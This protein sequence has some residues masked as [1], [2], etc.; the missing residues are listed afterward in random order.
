MEQK[1]IL[2]KSYDVQPFS[3]EDEY[4]DIEISSSA[5]EIRDNYLP[6]NF[7][8]NSQYDTERN[9]SRKFFVYGRLYGKQIDTNGLLMTL[10]TSDNDVL[11]VPNKKNNILQSGATS[12]S[13]ITKPLMKSSSLS[14]NIFDNVECSYYFQFEIDNPGLNSGNTKT[15]SIQVSGDSV[16]NQLNTP[17]V[18]Y[19]IDG[20]YVPYGT[21]DTVFD[22]NYNLI[23]INNNF[24]FLYDYHW[25]KQDFDV[26][27]FNNIYFPYKQYSDSNGNIMIDN[28]TTITDVN[29]NP[30]FQVLMDYPSFYG[31]EKATLCVVKA[32]KPKEDYIVPINYF[33]EQKFISFSPWKGFPN[34]QY[35]WNVFGGAVSSIRDL[36]INN[37]LKYGN[38]NI[39]NTPQQ[40][41]DANNRFFLSYLKGSNLDS[42]R[43]DVVE[44]NLIVEGF[45]DYSSSVYKKD[46]DS[47]IVG[48]F[49]S[50]FTRDTGN[51]IESVKIDFSQGEQQKNYNINLS[52]VTFYNKLDYLQVNFSS[53]T[54]VNIGYPSNYLINVVAENKKPTASFYSSYDLTQENNQDF[55]VTINLDK[56]YQNLNPTILKIKPV[57]SKTTAISLDQAISQNPGYPFTV[58]FSTDGNTK[59]D[60]EIINDTVTINNGDSTASFIVRIYYSN[61]YFLNKTLTLSLSSLTENILI[62]QFN[63]TFTLD[64]APNV[65]PGWT[66]YQFPADNLVGLGMFRSNRLI[67]DSNA[68]YNF[69]LESPKNYSDTR[70]NFTPSFGYTIECINAG[71]VEISYGGEYG[72]SQKNALPGD[73]VFSID[74]TQDFE[75]FNFVLPSNANLLEVPAINNPLSIT[76]KYLNS[77][78]KFIIKNIEP[79]NTA[80]TTSDSSIFENITIPAQEVFA[81]T[82]TNS[83]DTNQWKTVIESIDFF[84]QTPPFIPQNLS[85]EI[86]LLNTISFRANAIYE[87]DLQKSVFIL[88]TGI[89]QTYYPKP[90]KLMSTPITQVITPNDSQTLLGSTSMFGTIILN[91]SVNGNSTQI[92]YRGFTNNKSSSA[93]NLLVPSQTSINSL[94]NPV[95]AQYLGKFFDFE[96]KEFLINY[97]TDQIAYPNSVPFTYNALKSINFSPALNAG[98]NSYDDSVPGTKP[99]PV[100][101][102]INYSDLLIS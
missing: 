42:Q 71:D 87:A 19:D 38:L 9:N 7:D 27:T 14:R 6:N 23:D 65:V 62:D 5:K 41:Y 101:N 91:K 25:V 61:S 49:V 60:Y 4:I 50:G 70:Y 10:R 59:H 80:D 39:F 40:F 28:S 53:V 51:V 102:F 31:L 54:D 3:N 68:K 83:G 78:Y 74:S 97:S 86:S 72:G 79:V 12:F 73:T 33:D 63:S 69:E 44:D 100:Y 36:I 77:K 85:D 95:D 22:S 29:Q 35:E 2:L 88:R 56:T 21:I 30:S 75:Q 48:E 58:D 94:Q 8:L 67:S 15:V 47:T 76:P 45:L 55:K 11:Y 89:Q 34:T 92:I 93:L 96:Y 90:S 52:G 82:R 46:V 43:S 26:V 37:P 57:S 32:V 13:I 66:K 24:P 64:I 84:D 81:F 16:F 20:T 18:L 99:L 98:T 17:I 1:K